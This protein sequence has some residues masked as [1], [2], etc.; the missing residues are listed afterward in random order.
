MKILLALG[1]NA[2]LQRGQAPDAQ[3]QVQNAQHAAKTIRKIAKDHQIVLCH[4]NGPQVGFLSLIANTYKDV[5]PYPLDILVAQTQGMV[6][7]ML[8]QALYNEGFTN[9][10]TLLTQVAVD[11]ED[12]A[13]LTPTKPI[14]PVYDKETA[15]NLAK[16]KGWEIA[17]DGKFYRRVVASPEPKEIVEFKAALS[18]IDAGYL[19]IFCGGGGIPVVKDEKTK[20][21]VGK[22]AV[23]DKDRAAAVAAIELN[24]DLFIILSDVDAVYV[25][26]GKTTQRA[27]KTISPQQ[28]NEMNF[29]QGSM[30]PKIEAACEF[31][32]ATGKTAVIGDLFQGDSLINGT[33]G[34]TIKN[35]INNITYY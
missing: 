11:P 1:G 28:L 10:V 29:A 20:H 17:P 30:G 3:T 15:L 32:R 31:V 34:T 2:L 6:G 21:L 4:G 25:D 5:P 24:M 8:Q 16:E 19:V 35:G 33:S 9:V 26:W 14:G 7:Y 12:P 18:L 23:V 22:E 13:F 27:I